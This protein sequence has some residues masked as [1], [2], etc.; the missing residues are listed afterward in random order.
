M[1]LLEKAQFG[2][3]GGFPSP[4]EA[5]ATAEL[6]ERLNFDSLWVGDHVAFP[7]PI[8]D[9]LMQL[10]LVSAF[11]DKLI[12]GT[13]VFLL[14]L[15]NPTVVAKQVA[16][17]DRMTGGNRVIFGVGIGGEFPNEYA[18]CGVDVRERGARLSA[19]IPALKALWKDEEVSYDSEFYQFDK[20]R[21]LPAPPTNGGPPIWCGGRAEAALIRAAQMADGY[22]S[23]AVNAAMFSDSLNQIEREFERAGRDQTFDTGHLLF[24]RIDNDFETAHEAA[25]KHLSQR[26]AMDFSRPAKKYSALGTPADIAEVMSGYYE[27][28]V[29][30][31][32]LDLV[33]PMADRNSQLERFVSEVKPLLSF[34]T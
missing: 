7:V 27:A 34:P 26:Y 16:T 23:Y 6:A 17:L 8:L 25:T 32:I 31:F 13:C 33:G 12:I 18:A 2:F 24:I 15:R 20:V 3:I 29:R 1:K 11:T 28:G 19:G 30:H 4:N 14:P 22:V 21:M 9:S 5:K 10:A